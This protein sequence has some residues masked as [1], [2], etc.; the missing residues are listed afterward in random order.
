MSMDRTKPVAADTSEASRQA[1]VL[2]N[3][4][5]G[6]LYLEVNDDTRTLF[7]PNNLDGKEL[8]RNRVYLQSRDYVF[9]SVCICE[10]CVSAGLVRTLIN[11]PYPSMAQKLQW[12]QRLAK[13]IVLICNITAKIPYASKAIAISSSH[14]VPRSS[15][16]LVLF[17][18]Q[19]HSFL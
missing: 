4:V 14:F 9:L 11:L 15:T 18:L 2:H 3:G 16:S 8:S 1:R 7:E 13:G 6:A 5:L 10:P 19:R 12:P 17:S